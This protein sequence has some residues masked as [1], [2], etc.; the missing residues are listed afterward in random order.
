MNELKQLN[1]SMMKATLVMMEAKRAKSKPGDYGLRDEDV[2]DVIG[3]TKRIIQFYN[4]KL[5]DQYRKILDTPGER[6]DFI[7]RMNFYYQ[8][9]KDETDLV[10]KFYWESRILLPPNMADMLTKQ[11]YARKFYAGEE[12]IDFQE[13]ESGQNRNDDVRKTIR[14]IGKYTDLTDRQS[15]Y[16]PSYFDIETSDPGERYIRSSFFTDLFKELKPNS[17]LVLIAKLLTGIKL[18]TPGKYNSRRPSPVDLEAIMNKNDLPDEY[19][20][21][22]DRIDRLENNNVPVTIGNII[23]G[24][25]FKNDQG[26]NIVINPLIRDKNYNRDATTDIKRAVAKL[27]MIDDPEDADNIAKFLTEAVR[28]TQTI[29]KNTVNKI[30]NGGDIKYPDL[31]TTIV[32][33]VYDNIRN[34]T[35]LSKSNLFKNNSVKSIARYYLNTAGTTEGNQEIQDLVI[36]PVLHNNKSKAGIKPSVKA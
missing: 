35:M 30:M 17:R 36:A 4:P 28:D 10:R 29:I 26:K 20:V 16:L 32:Y 9:M 23:Q 33:C 19:W 12:E 3:Y 24:G 7:K 34:K 15:A 5:M 14:F 21:I 11:Y 25:T 31:V 2:A 6:E 22:Q 13:L 1:L 27:G 8:K 18:G